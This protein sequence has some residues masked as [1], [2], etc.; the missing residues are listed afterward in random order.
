[1]YNNDSD[2]NNNDDDNNNN[3]ESSKLAVSR[4][5]WVRLYLNDDKQIHLGLSILLHL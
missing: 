3:N 2:N 1:M 4:F 5:G